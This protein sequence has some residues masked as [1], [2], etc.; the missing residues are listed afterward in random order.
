MTTREAV[1]TPAAISPDLVLRAPPNWTAVVFFSVLSC[2]HCTIAFPAFYHGRWEGYMSLIFAVI[3]AI[4]TIIFYFARY[5]M[6]ILPSQNRIRL[7]HRIG[8]VKFQ[9]YI[10]FRDVHAVRLTLHGPRES[11]H[12]IALR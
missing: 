7:R 4:T 11:R 9:R 8:P 2:L 10:S 5:E 1:D 3:F 12:R 6:A